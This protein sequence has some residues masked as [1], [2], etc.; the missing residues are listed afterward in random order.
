MKKRIGTDMSICAEFQI[1][2]PETQQVPI[3]LAVPPPPPPPGGGGGG[4]GA[5]GRG[6][7]GGAGGGGGRRR[8]GRT[9]WRQLQ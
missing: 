6:G 3:V 4:G 5:G 2:G 7:G 1:R 9:T 8:L